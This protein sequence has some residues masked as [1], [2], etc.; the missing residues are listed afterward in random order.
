MTKMPNF[1][2]QDGGRPPF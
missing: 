1:E 2:N